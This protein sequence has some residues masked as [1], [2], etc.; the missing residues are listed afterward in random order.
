MIIPTLE[1]LDVKDKRVLVR[2]DFDYLFEKNFKRGKKQRFGLVVPTLK[3][4][5]DGNA[6]VIVAP[7]FKQIINKNRSEYSVEPYARY[8]CDLFKC[9]V[10]LTEQCVG[11][12]P[13]KLSKDM[14]PGSILF[15][16]NLYS[17]E[18]EKNADTE[19][20]EKLSKLSDI[21]V[22]EAISL[23]HLELASVTAVIDFFEKQN[24]FTGLNF[25]SEYSNMCRLNSEESVFT[26]CIN[27]DEDL[28]GSLIAAENLIEKIERILLLGELSNLYSV[29]KNG[30]ENHQ[31]PKNIVSK[32]KKIINS[33]EVR[34]IEIR[35]M[36]DYYAENE[37]K[38]KQLIRNELFNNKDSFLDIGEE[39][40]KI[41]S[42]AL[43]ETRLIL[44]LGKV[45]CNK[46]RD[47]V[48]GSAKLFD[49]IEKNEI[50]LIG[51]EIDSFNSDSKNQKEDVFF[52]FQ[53][54]CYNTFIKSISNEALPA[55]EK[56]EAK[57]K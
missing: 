35:C 5:L 36:V 37:E 22:N 45:P 53:S 44:W 12:V 41:F 33:A 25:Y 14:E 28:T 19:F 51:L 39:T 23:S 40:G 32:F 34:D 57:F 8:I 56:L 17:I 48:F 15:L 49:T 47:L 42:E 38:E 31:Y 6:K 20:A 24:I 26:L 9:N 4:L 52:N 13:L 1:N 29:I 54:S 7:S 55:I 16:E 50:F 3:Y 21:Y 2:L 11:D 27:N 43:S 10:Y 46:E 18:N 30:V